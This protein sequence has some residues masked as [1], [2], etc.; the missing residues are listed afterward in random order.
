MIEAIVSKTRSGASIYFH[1][2]H[3]IVLS[4]PFGTAI[5]STSPSCVRLWRNHPS[6][7]LE[8]DGEGDIFSSHPLLTLK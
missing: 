1:A 3:T 2:L 5:I 4:S 7:S 8:Y 6:L